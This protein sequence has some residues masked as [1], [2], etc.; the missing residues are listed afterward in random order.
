MKKAIAFFDFDGTITTKDTLL[1]FIRFSKGNFRFYLGF[2]L[3]LHFL[4]AYKL[5][6]ISNQ[7]AKE[8]VLRYFFQG[9]PVDEFRQ[10]C[11]RFKKER[12]PALIRPRALAEIEKLQGKGWIVV[13]VSASPENWIC[14]WAEERKVQLIASRLQ[15]AESKLT[16]K[17]EGRN[18]HGEEK[19]RRILESHSMADYEVI[20]AYGDTRGDRPMLKLATEAF[21]RP[22]RG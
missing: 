18:C 12:L 6:I 9:M 19:V 16:G 2:F 20:Y 7:A 10:L 11:S 3:N 21:Y 1:Q 22:F 5:K 15:V 8:K 17:I 14:E 13:V 4:M